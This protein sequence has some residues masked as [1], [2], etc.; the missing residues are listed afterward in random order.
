MMPDDTFAE[1]WY[2]ARRRRPEARASETSRGVMLQT[3]E[4]HTTPVSARGPPKQTGLSL[5]GGARAGL[6]LRPDDRRCDRAL[7]CRV[8]RQGL[9][10]MHTEPQ[11]HIDDRHHLATPQGEAQQDR[12]ERGRHHEGDRKDSCEHHPRCARSP[13]AASAAP[14]HLSRLPQPRNLA[15]LV[16]PDCCSLRGLTS[17]RVLFKS[18]RSGKRG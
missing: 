18:C 5:G 16:A 2:V 7:L 6:S 4:S 3:A 1:N 12:H 8:A 17:S 11:R 9:G 14:L 10:E 13:R 15:P